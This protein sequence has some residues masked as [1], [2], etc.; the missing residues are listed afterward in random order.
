M[1]QT[2][3]F[4]RTET[5]QLRI[6]TGV[7]QQLSHKALTKWVN[8][9][10]LGGVASPAPGEILAHGVSDWAVE[11]REKSRKGGRRG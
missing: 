5:I 6:E 7:E 11:P 4:Q 2:V 3:S 10:G 8:Q 1:K 9:G